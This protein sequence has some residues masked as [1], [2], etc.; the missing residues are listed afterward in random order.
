[1]TYIADDGTRFAVPTGHATP[2]EVWKVAY[3]TCAPQ[4]VDALGRMLA[5]PRVVA[6]GTPPPPVTIA[7][8]PE[9]VAR[10]YAQEL[11]GQSMVYEGC[12]A[13]FRTGLATG[14][15]HDT[16]VALLAIAAVFVG[17][18]SVPRSVAG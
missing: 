15:W 8:T 9:G 17:V 1:M 6:M 7:T 4:S 3:K 18:F 11:G 12:L 5:Y 14:P 10:R 16:L 13:G 2:A